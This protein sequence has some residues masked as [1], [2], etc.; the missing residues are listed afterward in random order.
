MM[1]IWLIIVLVIILSSVL[2][3]G[4]LGFVPGL[5]AVMGSNKPRDLGVKYTQADLNSL[6]AKNGIQDAALPDT[7]NP[8]GSLVYSGSKAVKA[9]FTQAELTARMADNEK[10]KFNP[11]SDTQLK[12]NPDGTAEVSGIMD[13]NMVGDGATA[14]GMAKEDFE[15]IMPYLDQA[16]ALNSKPAFYAKGKVSVVNNQ[17]SMDLDKAE[18]GRMPLP[19]DQIPMDTVTSEFEDL[20]GN[21]EGLNIKSLQFEDGKMSFDGT[22]PA[23]VSSARKAVALP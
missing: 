12:I 7:N 19:L 23:K 1:K 2:V 22:L 11:V 14:F 3:M 17:L 20:M 18:I 15:K 10:I 6:M 9:D 8:A 4:Y 13:L 5:S 21:V 16:K